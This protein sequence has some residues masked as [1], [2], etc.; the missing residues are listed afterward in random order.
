M[1][2]RICYHHSISFISRDVNLKLHNVNIISYTRSR[3][4]E[5]DSKEKQVLPPSFFFFHLS[6]SLQ[7]SYYAFKAVEQVNIYI[8][9]KKI[10]K[11][12]DRF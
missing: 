10:E 2:M 9:K 11:A 4:S 8:M 3:G 12:R 5:P 6:P 7:C 1:I